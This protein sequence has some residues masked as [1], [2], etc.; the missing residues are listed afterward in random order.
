MNI[1]EVAARKLVATLAAFGGL[2]VLPRCHLPNSARPCT[3]I[4]LSSAL[5]R[6]VVGPI[7]WLIK[8]ATPVLNH[9][10]RVVIGALMQFQRHDTPWQVSSGWRDAAAA[11][12]ASEMP[13]LG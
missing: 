3:A 8:H 9:L 7:A 1:L 5:R 2:V 11:T 10:L 13:R 12:A 6:P 4:N